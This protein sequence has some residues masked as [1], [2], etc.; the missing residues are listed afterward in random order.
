MPSLMPLEAAS[1]S[2]SGSSPK[3]IVQNFT[4]TGNTID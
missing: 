2:L 3:V 1:L 4:T